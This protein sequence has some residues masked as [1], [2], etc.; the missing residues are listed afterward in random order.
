ML[1][2][3]IENKLRIA[4]KKAGG[5]AYKF[6]S[7]GND[8]VPDRIIVL[9]GN[10]IGFVELKQ[11]GKKPTPLQQMQIGFLEKAGCTVAVMDDSSDIS[12]IISQIQHNIC[13]GSG[14]DAF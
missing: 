13:A 1:E 12:R 11:K 6:V 5:R 10:H 3:D 4:V 8:G 2:K 9:P 14:G 7:P